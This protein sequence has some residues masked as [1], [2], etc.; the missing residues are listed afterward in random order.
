MK[1]FINLSN[2]SKK[3]TQSGFLNYNKKS[4]YEYEILNT[5]I[6]FRYQGVSALSNALTI[7]GSSATLG[8]CFISTDWYT[9]SKSNMITFKESSDN[10]TYV[11]NDIV[12][13]YVSNLEANEFGADMYGVEAFPDGKLVATIATL[14]NP[15]AFEYYKL[16]NVNLDDSKINFAGVGIVYDFVWMDKYK[17]KPDNFEYIQ[18]SIGDE[19]YINEPGHIFFGGSLTEDYIS[20]YSI[21][22]NFVEEA[23]KDELLNVFLLSRAQRIFLYDETTK[24]IYACNFSE[25]FTTQSIVDGA[26]NI[27]FSFKDLRRIF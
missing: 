22:L 27:S 25:E 4:L 26:Y 21:N 15:N 5:Q 3:T 18:T 10:V 23:K 8:F 1:I 16:E 24:Y 11:K 20:N 7:L 19:L 9:L 17:T 12:N 2:F 13:V 14:K 6:K